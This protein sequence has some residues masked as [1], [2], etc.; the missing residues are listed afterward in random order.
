MSNPYQSPSFDPKQF[1]D[2]PAYVPP[3]ANSYGTVY[4]VRIVSIL[5]AVQGMLEIP[6]GLFYV[7]LAFFFPVMIKLDPNLKN[8]PDPPPEQMFWILAAVY[9]AIGIPVLLAGVLRIVAGFQNY[10]YKSR[11]LGFVSFTL[12]CR[13]GRRPRC[14]ASLKLR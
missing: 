10:R 12:S 4:Q 2:V 6:M 11:M 9:L 1:Q 13:I 3:P 5:N 7:V 8:R 14:R